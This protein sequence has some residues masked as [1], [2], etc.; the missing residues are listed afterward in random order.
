MTKSSSTSTVV[1]K[2][3]IHKIQVR[4]LEGIKSETQLL[5]A[6]SLL[7]KPDYNDVVTERSIAQICGY[8]LCTNSLLSSEP[9]NKGGKYRISLKEH[10]VYD[11]SETRMY[12]STKCVVNS[13]AYTESLLDER[14]LELDRGK[15]DKVMREFEGL[16]LEG[17]MGVK[18]NSDFGLG[19]LVIKEKENTSGNVGI[20]SMEEWIGP[21]NAIEGYVPQ[22]DRNRPSGMS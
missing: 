16:S 13:R 3:V 10:K 1:M 19:K 8:P 20:V 12:C 21:S 5:I 4:L 7:S 15:V 18:E 11:L 22:H 9:S 14:L 6:A 2:D 17:E